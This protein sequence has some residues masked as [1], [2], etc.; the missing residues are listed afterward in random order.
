MAEIFD[1][2]LL[3]TN[4]I[5][6]PGNGYRDVRGPNLRSFFPKRQHAPE[7]FLPSRPQV[8]SLLVRFRKLKGGALIRFRD[9]LGGFDVIHHPGV[10]ARELEEEGGN[11]LPSP[12]GPACSID[13]THLNVIQ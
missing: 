10:S 9:R 12:V 7:G 4:N 13:H 11:L 2:L 1:T 6:Q 3:R 5:W 8:A